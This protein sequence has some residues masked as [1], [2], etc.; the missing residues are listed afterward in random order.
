MPRTRPS[1]NIQALTTLLRQFP[2]R[3]QVKATEVLALAF[4][5]KCSTWLTIG[6]ALAILNSA[7]PLGD[8][9]AYA[10]NGAIFVRAA[11]SSYWRAFEFKLGKPDAA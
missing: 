5:Q 6:E 4:G 7:Y 11:D 2:S 8:R 10:E 9:D 1:R 3:Q